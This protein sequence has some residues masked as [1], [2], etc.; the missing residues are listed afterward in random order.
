MGAFALCQ[1]KGS[2]PRTHCPLSASCP[3]QLSTRPLHP[4]RKS[5]GPTPSADQDLGLS[6]RPYPVYLPGGTRTWGQELGLQ[7]GGGMS[8]QLAGGLLKGWQ[9]QP[10]G[11]NPGQFQGSLPRKSM[12]PSSALAIYGAWGHTWKPPGVQA[13]HPLHPA[14]GLIDPYRSCLITRRAAEAGRG[15]RRLRRGQEGL[16]GSQAGIKYLLCFVWPLGAGWGVLS[17]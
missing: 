9:D 3:P 10:T 15:A 6:P 5:P 1:V 13:T 12:V 7:P 16:L 8:H 2:L 17:H 11:E 14:L 4:S